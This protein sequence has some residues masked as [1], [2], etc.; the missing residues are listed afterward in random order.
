MRRKNHS[1]TSQPKVLQTILKVELQL[2]DRIVIVWKSTARRNGAR[3]IIS[4]VYRSNVWV[5][6]IKMTGV[7]IN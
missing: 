7:N 4:K 5:N 3:A 2:S 1:F 6:H